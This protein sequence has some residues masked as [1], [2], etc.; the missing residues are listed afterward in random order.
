MCR[1]P[2]FYTH[3]IEAAFNSAAIYVERFEDLEHIAHWKAVLHRPQDD[4]EVFADRA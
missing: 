3:Q 2:A 4:V 1:R